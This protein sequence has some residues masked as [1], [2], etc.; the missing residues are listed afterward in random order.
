MA[1]SHLQRLQGIVSYARFFRLQRFS[2]HCLDGLRISNRTR[3]AITKYNLA[4]WALRDSIKYDYEDHKAAILEAR[5][6]DL[7]G[8]GEQKTY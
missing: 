4:L 8:T 1:Q 2:V 3:D 7:S 6:N 5:K